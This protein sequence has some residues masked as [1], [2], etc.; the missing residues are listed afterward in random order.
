MKKTPLYD[1]HLAAGAKMVD[2]GEWLMPLHYGSQIKEHNMVRDDCGM[3]DVSHMCV[4][5]INGNDSYDFLRILLS[6]DI[7]KLTPNK[8]LYSCIL[9]TEAKVIDDVIVYQIADNNYRLV[10]NALTTQ[11]IIIWIKQQIKNFDIRINMRD[12]LA[13]IAVQGPNAQNKVF[14]AVGGAREMCSNMRN[15]ECRNI[16]ELLI[17]TTGYTGEQGFEIILPKKAAPFV[18]KMLLDV[19]VIPCGLGARDTL[20]MEAGMMLS[21]QDINEE[22]TPFES[23]LDFTVDLND[24]YRDFI[25]KDKLKDSNQTIKGLMLN[26]R[27]VL[28]AGQIVSTDLGFGVITSGSYSPTIKHSIAFARVDRNIVSAKVKIRNKYYVTKIIKLPFVYKEK[29]VTI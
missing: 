11:K 2:F 23:G 9:N 8:A 6:A 10:I 13:I 7:A 20:R 28:R 29:I 25:G 12:S 3:F 27:A 26:E 19:G 4:I 16:G 14:D 1:S 22:V 5:D 15:F 24:K 21:G 18:W 17:A